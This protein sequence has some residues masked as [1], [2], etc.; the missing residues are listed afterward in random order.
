MIQPKKMLKELRS[1]GYRVI[2]TYK[3]VAYKKL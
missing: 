3:P 2:V 1:G